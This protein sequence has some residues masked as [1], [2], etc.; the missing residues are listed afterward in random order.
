MSS[1]QPLSNPDLATAL[2]RSIHDHWRTFLIEGIILV[3]LGLAA[4]VVPPIAGLATTI[5][6][7]WVLFVGGVVG[8]I[9]TYWARHMPGNWWSL[10]SA[11][12]ALFAGGVLLWYPLQG[13][14]TLTYVMIAYFIADGVLT[15]ILAIEHRRQLAGRWEW[16]ALSGVVNL[17]L[18]GIIIAAL[19]G[20]FEWAI[21]L[22][23]GIDL[24]FGGTSLIGMAL[25]A[26]STTV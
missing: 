11:L 21:G 7:G 1:M 2:K 16:M 10:L 15:I 22:L 4:I 6:I 17:I 24:V 12:V 3:V 13:L 14:V 5:F 25:A 9:A 19:P 26:R 20:S 18:A 8:L 23:V